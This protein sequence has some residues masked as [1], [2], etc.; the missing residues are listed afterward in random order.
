MGPSTTVLSDEAV[1]RVLDPAGRP[2]GAGFLTVDRHVM[3]CAHVVAAALG[4]PESAEPPAGLLRV[5]FP[6]AEP[7]R[8]VQARVLAW[9]PT[10][11]DESGDVA[12][13][14]LLSDPPATAP[15]ARLVEHGAAPGLTVRTFGFPLGYQDG[16]WS[17]GVLRGRQATGWLQ[18]DADPA[19]QYEVRRG[20]SGAPVWDREHGG[21]VGMV[22]AVDA[23]A[24][25][26]TGYLIPT[27]TLH[28]CWPALRRAVLERSPFRALRP[29]QEA[30]A[31]V[32]H[33]REEPARR[34]VERLGSGSGVTLVGASGVGKSSLLYAGVL[35]ALRADAGRAVVVFQPGT[36]PL[37]S[38]S[39]ALLPLLE[40]DVAEADRLRAAER[41]AGTLRAGGAPEVV[42]QVLARWR[43]HQLLLLA[44][45]FEQALVRPDDPDLDAFAAVLAHCREPGSPLQVVLALRADFLATALNHPGVAPLLDDGRLFT[46]GPM[47]REEVRAA[48]ERPPERVGVRYEPGLVDRLLAD[49]G[50]EPGR[51]PLLEF[52]LSTLWDLQRDGLIGHAQYDSLGGLGKALADHAERVWHQLRDEERRT[53]RTL[54]VQLADPR[55]PGESPTRRTVPRTGLTVPQWRLAQRLMTTRLLVPGADQ[56]TP[57]GV[58]ESVELAHETLLTAWARLSEFVGA[59]EEFRRWQEELRG[60]IT[61]WRAEGRPRN[62]LP[63]GSDLRDATRWRQ[64]RSVEL[65]PEERE[66]VDA[67]RS[68]ARR[69]R[70]YA[71]TTVTVLMTVA[72]AG[73]FTWRHQSEVTARNHSTA[74]AAAALVQQ[75]REAA[76]GS[77]RGDPYTGLL[78]AMRAYRTWDTPATRAQLAK[79]YAVYGA[80]YAIVPD[81]GTA[82]GDTVAALSDLATDAGST[83]AVSAD[84]R[85]AITR[86]DKSEVEVWRLA[87]RPPS[88]TSTGRSAEVTAVSP[89]GSLVAMA[90]GTG[91]SETGSMLEG[92]GGPTVTLYDTRTRATRTLQSPGQ[93]DPGATSLP[94]A[95][96]SPPVPIP[97]GATVP[98][99][100]QGMAFDP[101]GTRLAALTAGR[102]IVWDLANGRIGKIMRV[103]NSLETYRFFFGPDGRSLITLSPVIPTGGA[104]LKGGGGYAVTTWDLGE[105]APRPRI[106]L[107]LPW[108]ASPAETAVSADGGALAVAGFHAG[109][110]STGDVS[111]YAL[112]SGWLIRRDRTETVSP[113]GIV[114][115]PG[116]RRDVAYTTPGRLGPPGTSDQLP[117][118]GVILDPSPGSLALAP[119]WR[120]VAL[121]GRSGTS[122]VLLA[123]WGLDAFVGA[124][125]DGDTLSKVPAVPPPA[126]PTASPFRFPT[127][128]PDAPAS[129]GGTPAR[130]MD[131]LCRVVADPNLRPAAERKL[132]P[133]AYRG[134]LCP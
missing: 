76:A 123:N 67:A 106:V 88:G 80:A 31:E 120:S 125:G 105:A 90:R 1:V 132:P 87:A 63:R 66:F 118:V 28:D 24:G 85:V 111:V 42:R 91:Y 99:T 94:S 64:A 124:S 71:L 78:L 86:D 103:P 62:R 114:L 5:D 40:P 82:A 92:Q 29:F 39:R 18:Y 7:G 72:A 116:G 98:T 81:Y 4:V 47:T 97:S 20:F 30:D 10:R 15:L 23:R 127:L 79:E 8:F 35:P 33:G 43:K 93:G 130:W 75:S 128:D 26:R 133:G 16:V 117:G 84:G 17:S 27:E 107:T 46:L 95:L 96:A 13:L 21:V 12:V 119:P 36:S 134:P 51:L 48:V 83:L 11:P 22:V 113:T 58:V 50:S 14:R 112:P 52:T 32:F 126:V 73:T 49:F 109:W 2:V 44:D 56:V 55:G 68:A 77:G 70:W 6:L 121:L 9:V 101:G 34:I 54:L 110:P 53:A 129:P 89:D 41:V 37:E 60:R 104:L 19:S 57:G 115:T 3:T 122:A 108:T 69:R 45:Q 102:L 59:D 100:Y 131:R 74:T 38:L 61:R 65:L 25:R